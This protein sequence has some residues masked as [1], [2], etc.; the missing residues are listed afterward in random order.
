MTRRLLSLAAVL[1]WSLVALAMTVGPASAE[2]RVALVLGNSSYKNAALALVNARFD[3]EDVA[4]ALTSLGFEVLTQTD[5]DI[6]GTNKAIQQFARMAVGADAALFFY[7]G[8]ALQYQGQNFLLPVDADVKDEISLPFETVSIENVRAILDRSS[9]I[10]IMVLDACRNNPV[11]ERLGKIAALRPAGPAGERTRGLERTDSAAGR[12]G[13]LIVAYAT[14]PDEVA[15]DGQGRNSPFTKAFLR[16]LSEPGLEIEA[17]FRRVASDVSAQTGGRQRPETYVSLLGEYYLNR[18]DVAAWEKVKAAEDPAVLREF[19]ERYPSSFYAIEARYRLQALERALADAKER[20]LREAETARREKEA[21]AREAA[22]RRQADEACQKDRAALAAAGPRDETGLRSLAGS[23]SCDEVKSGAQKRLA[24]LESARA[25][26]VDVCRRDGAALA[27]ADQGD[28]VRLGE[29]LK[30]TRCGDIKTAI[31]EKTAALEAAQAK[32]AELCRRE[33][34]ELKALAGRG[35][36]PEFETLRARA[37]CP[38]TIAAI[39][40]ALS[41]FA[42]ATDAACARDGA[43]LD[44]IGPRDGAA[45]R[46]LIG[47]APCDRVKS[48]AA[49]RLAELD[50]ALA[51]EAEACRREDAAVKTLT[52][53]GSPKDIGAMRQTAQCPAAIAAI[54]RSLR[55]LAAA[56]DAACAKDNAALAAIGPRD[57]DG[58]R[59]LASRATCLAIKTSAERRGTELEALLA[60]E[61]EQCASDQSQ[62]K[63]LANSGDRAG[64]ESFRQRAGCPGVVAEIDSRLAAL[65]TICRRDEASLAA[66]GPRDAAG[67]RTFVDTAVCDDVKTPARQ[68]LAKLEAILAQEE[69]T[70]QRDETAWRPLAESG[71][72][73][74]IAAFRKN[75]ECASVTAAA[76][77]RLGELAVLCRR[78]DSALAQIGDRDAD[79]L[80]GFAEKTVCEDVKTNAR[81]R[82]AKLESSIAREAEICQRDEADFKTASAQKDRAG[83]A[84]LRQRAGCPRVVAEIDAAL[85]D[86]KAA[87]GRDQTA[88]AAM[89]QNDVDAARSL[90]ARTS[91]DDI[92]AAARAKIASLEAD[93]AR[94]EETCRR[95]DLELTSLQTQGADARDRLVDLRRGLGCAK[96]RPA[97]EAALEQL[98][99]PPAQPEVNTNAQILSAQIELRRLGCASGRNNGILDA[100][101]EKA[102]DRYFQAL[103]RSPTKASEIRIDDDFLLELRGYKS[104]ICAPPVTAKPEPSVEPAKPEEKPPH[105]RKNEIANYPPKNEPAPRASEPKPAREP[106]EPAREKAARPAPIEKRQP[107]REARQPAPRERRPAPAATSSA[108]SGGGAAGGGGGAG[109]LGVGF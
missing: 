57:L 34:G 66:L 3:A 12:P 8:H 38:A 37:T 55:E 78:E 13:G 1:L 96:L 62:W 36:S 100:K 9:G 26:E 5:A 25:A 101:M 28:P 53:R 79:A 82:L 67:L 4:A 48:A 58:L 21:L 93:L 65:K 50:A 14:A 70:C 54:D 6:A 69:A 11:A 52:E 108:R 45:L 23:A 40:R 89:G 19:I 99:P 76:D 73:A 60:R 39:D 44:A 88:L 59:S 7:A 80:R 63:A 16:R 85:G 103:G 51:R 83:L 91:C 104:E 106:R 10:K 102:L 31:L 2:R 18:A 49:A 94:Q 64:V 97:L 105:R 92:K 90:L 87:C 77:R 84:A 75:A 74:G 61:A 71:D 30:T 98:P 68:R 107:Q 46:A 109:A 17:M 29:L 86:L 27:A 47:K 72:R 81:Q 22:A 56:A 15:L 41:E 20:A 35:R 95:E 33:N 32:Q 24:D 43:A 42:A